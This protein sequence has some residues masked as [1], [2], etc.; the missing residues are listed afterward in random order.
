[1]RAPLPRDAIWFVMLAFALMAIRML[2]VHDPFVACPM[3]TGCYE[4]GVL[5]HVDD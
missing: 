3:G 4:A 1:M 2:F 5:T